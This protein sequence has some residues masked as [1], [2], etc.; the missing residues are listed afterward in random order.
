MKT[1]LKIKITVETT[2][3]VTVETAWKLWTGPEHVI[4]WNRASEDWHTPRAE[5]DLRPGGEF[6]YRMEAKD[7]SAGFD[8]WGVYDE[9]KTGELLTSTL[10]DGRRVS[11]AFEGRGDE[12][13]VTETFEA[14][15][16]HTP[17]RQRKGWQSIL[18]SFKRYAEKR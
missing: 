4:R 18:D 12:T 6:N 9:V 8:F 5:N 14:E 2:V 7:G 13:V 11:V 16:F 3:G 1:D 10:G 17:E 15:S